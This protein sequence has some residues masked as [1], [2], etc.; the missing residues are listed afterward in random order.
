MAGRPTRPDPLRWLWYALGG[1]LSQRHRGWVLHD[2]TCRTWPLRHFA[3]ACAQLALLTVPLL[4]IVP[5]PLW[6]RLAAVLLGWLVALQYTL[7]NM[8]N[9]VEH[10]VLKAGFAPGTTEAARHAATADQRRAAAA[11]YAQR[12]RR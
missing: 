3:R 10:R 9:S 4:L 6:L 8:H 5:G 1:A 12:Y 2:A 11:R 7:F